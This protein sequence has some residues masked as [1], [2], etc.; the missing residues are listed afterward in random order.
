MEISGQLP[1]DFQS[2][3]DEQQEDVI[4]LIQFFKKRNK[5]FI[6]H[7]VDETIEENYE[8]FKKLAE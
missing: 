4:A 2:L 7:L 1:A 6:E 3:S 5:E 8:A